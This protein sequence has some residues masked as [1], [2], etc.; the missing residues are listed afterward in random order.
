MAEADKQRIAGVFD[1]AAPM[2]EQTGV[3]FFEPLGAALAAH[4]GLRPGERILDVG[5]GRGASLFP[6]AEAVG[7]SG[8]AIG[9]DLAPGMV[10]A[11]A[12]EARRRGLAHLHVQVGDAEAPDFPDA[13][14]D[15]VL[16]GLML[17][18]LPDAP[19]AVQAY[20]RLLRPG[21][22]LVLSTFT[23]VSDA[24]KEWF[25]HFGQALRPY[26][27]PPPE[28]VPGSPPPPDARLRTRESI[29][30]LLT[31]GGF[32]GVRFTEKAHRTVFARPEQFWDW[33]W[34]AGMRGM[35]ES[36]PAQDR[37]DARA[38]LTGLV[39]ERLRSEDGTLGWTTTIRLTTARR[40]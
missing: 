39:A 2:Y 27:P 6:A 12:A 7:P 22:R 29:V 17:F 37:D 18:F 26:L 24:D 36:I 11:T 40:P 19:A 9:I 8:A 33:L 16:A 15:A 5:C 32:S 30:E 10:E 13:S 28:P 23:E 4:A 14:F 34:S 31:G 3:A 21:G 38:A 20:A 25:G 35:M 1:R